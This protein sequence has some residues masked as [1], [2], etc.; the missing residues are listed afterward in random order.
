VWL[1]T[2]GAVVTAIDFSAS[3]LVQARQ[4]PGAAAIRFVVHDLHDPLPFAAGSFDVVVSGLVVE[5]LHDLSWFFGEMHRVLRVGGRT[6]VSAMHPAMFLRG[7]Q[8]RFT[9]PDSGERVQPGSYDHPLGDIVM[10]AL[11][12]GFQ[13]DAIGEYA[14]DGAFAGEYPRAEKYVGWPMLLVLEMRA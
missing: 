13:L 4:K 9:D 8:A 2:A 5:H 14:P 12:A 3:M 10:A 6:V 1:A 7:S 11:R